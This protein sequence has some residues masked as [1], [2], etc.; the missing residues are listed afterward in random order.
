MERFQETD[1][2]SKWMRIID[3]YS[4]AKWQMML[5]DTEDEIHKYGKV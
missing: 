5:N 3:V 2:I 4:A 1:D